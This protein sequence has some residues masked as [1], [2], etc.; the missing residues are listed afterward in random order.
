MLVL[1]SLLL[2][3]SLII[4]LPVLYVSNS[5]KKI[6]NVSLNTVIFILKYC[7]TTYKLNKWKELNNT[8]G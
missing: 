7:D 4:G 8:Q 1:C 6:L 5:E 2:I 3:R